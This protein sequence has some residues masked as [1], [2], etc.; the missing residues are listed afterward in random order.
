MIVPVALQHRM[1]RL[2]EQGETDFRKINQS[3]VEPVVLPG[4]LVRRLRDSG[5]ASAG[6]RAANDSVQLKHRP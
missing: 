6:T 4:K 3:R 1:L 5:T 2:V